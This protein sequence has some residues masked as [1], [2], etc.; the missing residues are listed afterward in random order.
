MRNKI[1]SNDFKLLG[2]LED[3]EQLHCIKLSQDIM[4]LLL[5]TFISLEKDEE[6][7]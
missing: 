1:G 5:V 4:I 6:E 2:D 3:L 7:E